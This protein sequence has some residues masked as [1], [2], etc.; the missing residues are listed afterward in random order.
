MLMVILIIFIIIIRIT[1]S[2]PESVCLLFNS[3]VLN[4]DLVQ[5]S[6]D[7]ENPQ[8]RESSWG[9]ILR[10]DIQIYPNA[11][12]L[13]AAA[14]GEGVKVFFRILCNGRHSA[15]LFTPKRSHSDQPIYIP[16]CG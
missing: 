12:E 10:S 6:I 1:I 8:L 7:R 4:N 16:F 5:L 11:L 3:C 14:G 13:I 15:K 2:K 9:F